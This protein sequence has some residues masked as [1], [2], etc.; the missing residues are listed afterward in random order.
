MVT[1]LGALSVVISA[2][3]SSLLL[4]ETLSFSGKVGCALCVV[5]SVILVLNAPGSNTTTTLKSFFDLAL[6]PSVNLLVVL[7]LVFYLSPKY[8]D[9]Y[10]FVPIAICSLVG[11]FVVSATQGLGSAVVYSLSTPRD[12]QFTDWRLYALI[13]FVLLSGIVQMNYLNKALNI[14][15]TAVVT[16]IYFVCFTTATLLC[17][18]ILLREFEGKNPVTTA[19]AVLGFIVIVGG[20]CLLFQYS[21]KLSKQAGTNTGTDTGLALLPKSPSDS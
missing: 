5:G 12:T 21:I 1:P 17:T 16:P 4:K 6:T 3:L 14:F 11:A 19:T 20:V 13:V 15:S 10:P 9:R 8:G 2:V 18:T 7:V